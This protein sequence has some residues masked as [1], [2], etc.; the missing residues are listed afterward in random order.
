[1]SSIKIDKKQYT[2]D[3]F[4][5]GLMLAGLISPVNTK[6]IEE[7][8]AIDKLDKKLKKEKSITYF[9]RAVLAAEIVSHMYN[10]FTFGRVK[11]QKLVYLCEHAGKMQ[12][13]A[14]YAKFAA[15]PFDNKFMHAINS[16]FKKQKWYTIETVFSNG[17]S[18]PKYV[19]SNNFEKYKP[20][21]NKYFSEFDGN[22]QQIIN[23]FKLEKTKKV[24]IVAT[25][26]YCWL[27]MIEKKQIFN[28]FSLIQ[29]FYSFADEKKQFKETEIVENLQ[30]MK[31]VGITPLNYN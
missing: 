17:Y 8:D 10:E 29:C 5:K 16:E 13:Q 20:Y 1:M 7:L 15:G 28:N 14:R 24:E 12:L 4:E 26:F 19:P 25:I 30:W 31:D 11:F 22:I 27:E 9:K 21:Y 2:I 6:E 3:D 18:K 23:L